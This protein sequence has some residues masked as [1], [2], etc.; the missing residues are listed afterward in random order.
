MEQWGYVRGRGLGPN[1][2]GRAAPVE[3]HPD[4]RGRGGGGVGSRGP[5]D[6]GGGGF[7]FAGMRSSNYT[8]IGRG[9][10][11]GEWEKHTRG[12]GGRMMA[13][14]G[15]RAGL[16]LG[17]NLAGR[18]D[19][20][21]AHPDGRGRHGGGGLGSRGRGGGDRDD[22]HGGGGYNPL[23][24]LRAGPPTPAELARRKKEEILDARKNLESY[25]LNI[26]STI[27]DDKLKEKISDSDREALNS[28][29]DEIIK[30]LNANQ[31]AEMGEFQEKAKEAEDMCFSI[32]NKLYPRQ[33]IR[34]IRAGFTSASASRVRHAQGVDGAAEGQGQGEPTSSSQVFQA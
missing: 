18:A 23:A 7:G 1:L 8:P 13:K 6:G 29:C 24:M 22:D 2:E 4:G 12:A 11:F 20:V 3:A 28:K 5:G 26:K 17:P 31:P 33:A 21:E 14:W 34:M 10:G 16:G 25:C 30:W 15:F 9:K 27:N 32:F 19:I